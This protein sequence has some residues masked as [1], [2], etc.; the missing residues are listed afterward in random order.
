MRA[1]TRPAGPAPRAGGRIRAAQP[2]DLER[3]RAVYNH[4]VLHTDA[5]LDTEEKSPED[6]REWFAEHQG[7]YRAG[8]YLDDGGRA[9]GYA[10]LSAFSRRGG[11]H[12]LAELSVYL[13]PHA[14]GRGCGT[15]LTRW[16]LDQAGRRDFATIVCFV[17][18]TNEA[19]GRMLARCGFERTGVMRRAGRKL[20]AFVDLG[21]WQA[22]LPDGPHRP[23]TP[24]V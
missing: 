19:S 17:T 13:A 4:A 6:F 3:L 20:G 18:T 24:G 12:P 21:I 14:Q 8:V 23:L 10:A 22:F 16:A 7:R 2:G 1:T 5:T 9:C 11:Y 15:A